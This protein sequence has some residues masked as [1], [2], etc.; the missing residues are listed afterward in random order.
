MV[1]AGEMAAG[2]TLAGNTAPEDGVTGR[3]LMVR[4]VAEDQLAIIFSTS[5]R[6][7]E[8]SRKRGRTLFASLNVPDSIAIRSLDMGSAREKKSCDFA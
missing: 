4:P 6:S 8:P 3:S 1:D 5:A 7:G 2:S